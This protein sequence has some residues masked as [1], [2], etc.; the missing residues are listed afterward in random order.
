MKVL[1]LAFAILH[2]LSHVIPSTV[3]A[4]HM[5]HM[6]KFHGTSKWKLIWAL[7]WIVVTI[8]TMIELPDMIHSLSNQC[9]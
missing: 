9:G 1:F 6:R 4:W 5:W 3:M 8:G 2:L 7:V